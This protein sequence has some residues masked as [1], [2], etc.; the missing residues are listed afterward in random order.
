MDSVIAFVLPML[1]VIITVAVFLAARKL[2]KNIDRDED[3]Q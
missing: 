3:G 1:A 2:I